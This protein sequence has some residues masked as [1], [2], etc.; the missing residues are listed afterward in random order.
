MQEVQHRVAN[1]LQI[2]A[3][4]L[5]QSAKRVQ[6]DEAR[7][8][9]QDAHS[10]VMS[11][12]AVQQ[13][14]ALS[15]QTSVE[16]QSY[17]TQLCKSLAASMIRDPAKLSIEINV[18]YGFVPSDMATSLGLIITELV[19]NSLKHA[20]PNNEG[21]IKVTFEETG[22]NHK[23]TVQDNGVGMPIAPNKAK[24]GLGT[25]LV[26][27]L[28]QKLDAE[29]VVADARPGTIFSLLFKAFEKAPAP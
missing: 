15:E 23:L 3:S 18:D 7:G 29:I 21:K 16:V 5:L 26:E 14:L 6:S 19:I 4:I 17:F 22:N 11:L 9:L 10:R 28:A 20:F 12:A 1:S 24:P 2:I 27:A 8:Q 25:S 13:Q